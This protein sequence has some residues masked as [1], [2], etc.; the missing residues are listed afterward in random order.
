MTSSGW[1]RKCL[2]P[3]IK[4]VAEGNLDAPVV[5]ES[6]SR[7]G[8]PAL[9]LRA[10]ALAKTGDL[11]GARED[12]ERT[13]LLEPSGAGVRLIAGHLNIA[14]LDFDRGIRLLLEAAELSP[15]LRRRALERAMALSDTV[16]FRS[17]VRTIA[18][19][20]LERAPE[21]VRAH[22]WLFKL[23]A[24]ARNFEAAIAHG[25]ALLG[26]RP[27]DPELWL[28]VAELCAQS[29]E[30]DESAT[31]VERA[32]T[33]DSSEEARLRGARLLLDCGRFEASRRL[34][35]P[36]AE[37]DHIEA[38]LELARLA[39]WSGEIEVAR[40][41]A[42]QLRFHPD[43]RRLLGAIAILERKYDDARALLE[44]V[45]AEAPWDAEAHTLVAEAALMTSDYESFERHA[46]AALAA[47]DRYLAAVWLLRLVFR[48][49]TQPK[50][51]LLLTAFA[52]VRPALDELCDRPVTELQSISGE[53]A[54]PILQGALDAL[55]GNR[56]ATLTRMTDGRLVRLSAKAGLRHRC[57]HALE[58]IRVAPFE[59][60]K[61]AL[62]QIIDE[63]PDAA[64]A[65]AHRGELHL[66][67]G[68]LA[69]ARLDLEQAIEIA[70]H[71]RWAYIGLCGV[72][73]LEGRPERGIV[74]CELGIERMNGTTGPAVYA[75]RGEALRL[76]G[77][78]DD[79]LRDLQRSV[80]LHPHRTSAQLNLALALADAGDEQAALGVYNRLS[81]S[82]RGLLSD[83]ASEL[84]ERVFDTPPDAATW[85]RVLTHA[86]TMMRGNRSSS[87]VTYLTRDGRLRLV[88]P[89]EAR[90]PKKWRLTQLQ[91]ART[92][93]FRLLGF[94]VNGTTG[95]DVPDD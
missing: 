59:T 84:R 38:R 67:F 57:R 20:I 25:H 34:L 4:A 15:K 44:P 72:E 63:Q 32:L 61:R 3:L 17:D 76:L 11:A 40:A 31:L 93:L 22:A 1:D 13:L 87:C 5:S 39:L 10:I 50:S 73:T 30:R 55:S 28:S 6:V 8:S 91:R 42:N 43:A 53:D 88:E 80:E 85:R 35:T 65:Y 18:E 26:L 82:A 14:L 75:Y 12:I 83:A 45:T 19:E 9:L 78:T 94:T 70:P 37:K 77:R 48:A 56:S 64:L 29:G 66:W 27:D 60:A 71:T 74:T 90:D 33:L 23:H 24:Q 79:A 54:L 16:G 95:P 7:F 36:L 51:Q 47:S 49:S 69:E 92:E 52:E 86:L 62:D 68:Q 21:D 58:L 41:S 81:Q 89:G 2:E 46:T